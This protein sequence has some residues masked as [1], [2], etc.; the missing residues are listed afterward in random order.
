ME[1]PILAAMLS[2]SGTKLT[3]AEKKLFATANPLGISLFARNIQNATQLKEL[4]KS[5]KET[6]G[7]QNVI[8]AT[9]EEGGR[10]SR[11]KPITKHPYASEEI[12]GE[13]DVIY[14]KMHAK[15]IAHDLKRYG[16]NTNYSPLVD[17]K[18]SI[19]SKV[20]M[21]RCFG[22]D[23]KKIVQYGK[24]IADSY[25]AEGICPCVKHI[26]GHFTALADPH[27]NI[28]S[29]DISL[30][31][32]KKKTQYLRSFANYPLIMTSHIV[33]K[34][35]D[36]RTPVTMSSKCINDLLRGYLGLQGLLISDAIDMH[37]LK[38]T[39]TERAENS[40]NAGTEIIC[41]CSGQY[42][43]LYNIYK[44]QRFMSE[45][46][47]IRFANIEKII[48]NANKSKDILRIRK[49]YQLEFEGKLKVN[50]IYDATEVLNQMLN[51]GE[52]A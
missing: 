16:I 25:I 12:L 32:I 36:E 13:A 15:L 30:N 38:G 5:I 17:K 31:E 48:H 3:D 21:N 52:N 28:I 6:I 8:I 44:L 11:L 33:L 43:D 23:T 42:Q 1:K 9:D 18:T 22:A 27:L 35:I 10:V 49:L 37:A 41:Y 14:S 50:Y 4:I 40:W 7:R 20:L 2:C 29:T 19:Q 26:P 34:A 24:A 45:K 46:S 39:I 47:L 51:K